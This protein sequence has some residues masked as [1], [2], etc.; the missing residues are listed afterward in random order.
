MEVGAEDIFGEDLGD[1][2]SDE[3]GKGSGK[4]GS[5]SSDSENDGGGKIRADFSKSK[6]LMGSDSSDEGDVKR[7]DD[8]DSDKMEVGAEDIFGE[9]LGD[10]SSDEEGKGSGKGGSG[11]SDS[12]NDGG[13][14]IRADFSL[15]RYPFPL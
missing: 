7:Y 15:C 14:K 9:D 10:I 12:D 3:E 1:I 13:G 5:G 4:G 2:S 8:N 6:K 11:S